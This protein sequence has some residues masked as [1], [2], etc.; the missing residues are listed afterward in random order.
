[1]ATT[2]NIR[3]FFNTMPSNIQRVMKEYTKTIH[4]NIFYINREV[5]RDE[6]DYILFSS[7]RWNMRP[8]VFAADEYGEIYQY[9]YP[10]ILTVN[11]IASIFHFKQE[12]FPHRII[13]KPTLETVF[14]VLSKN[15]W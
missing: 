9:I 12:N 6:S 3:N 2:T 11:N 5:L 1:M 8:H 7:N 4:N 10:V 15:K 14:S 13:L